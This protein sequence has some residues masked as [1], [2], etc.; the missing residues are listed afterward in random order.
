MKARRRPGSLVAMAASRSASARAWHSGQAST[1]MLRGVNGRGGARVGVAGRRAVMAPR[2][3]E[4]MMAS[5][6]HGGRAQ[7]AGS[8]RV[9]TRAGVVMERRSEAAAGRQ[10]SNEHGRAAARL[11][12]GSGAC[13][14]AR[15]GRGESAR[16]RERGERKREWREK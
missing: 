8:G 12:G 2:R 16:E 15:T 10:P 6:C 1:R 4:A 3:A 7:R 14:A 11:A 9:R 5:E 13:S